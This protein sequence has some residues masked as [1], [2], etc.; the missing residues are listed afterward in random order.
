MIKGQFSAI[1]DGI[2]AKNDRTLTIKLGTQEMTAEATAYLFDMMG[3]QVYCALA[4]TDIKTLEVPEI[5]PEMQGEKSSAQRLRGI[6]YKIWELKTDK[7]KPF[8]SYYE[9]YM[10]KL[11]ENLKAK[12]N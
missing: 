9:D 12:L 4:E 8:P 11:C 7:S 1:I 5:L 3:K 2:N 10:F 6:I